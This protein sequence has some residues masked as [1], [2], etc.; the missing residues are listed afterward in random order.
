MPPF[1]ICSNEECSY[2]ADLNEEGR[3]ELHLLPVRRPLC[4]RRVVF[5]CAV[6]CGPLRR[7]PDLNKPECGCCRAYLRPD[8]DEAKN[9]A[10]Q[11]R[12]MLKL[13]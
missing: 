10:T 12:L 13:Q 3:W 11:G 5:H 7:A 1:A 9:L 4:K 6:C 2:C 8:A